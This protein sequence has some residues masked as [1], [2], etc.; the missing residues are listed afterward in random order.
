[1]SYA[2]SN[3][4]VPDDEL[5][6]AELLAK[7]AVKTAEA[8]KRFARLGTAKQRVEIAR[9]V[10]RAVDAGIIDPQQGSYLDIGRDYLDN[11][12]DVTATGNVKCSACA[13]GSVFACVVAK[14]K[15]L[16]EVGAASSDEM[17][18]YLSRWFDAKQ[19]RLMEAAFEGSLVEP[20]SP[21]GELIIDEDGD[22]DA[23]LVDRAIAFNSRCVHG[24]TKLRRIMENIIAND[25]EFRP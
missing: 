12:Y 19:M 15:S 20:Y 18:K 6:F 22:D 3:D 2:R 5:K 16:L 8:N 17:L 1:M 13:I 14:T 7:D 25:G 4:N 10:M 23:E 11:T 21:D 9:D 24:K